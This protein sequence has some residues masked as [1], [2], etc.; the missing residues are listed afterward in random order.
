MYPHAG[1][2]RDSL[3][4]SVSPG[5]LEACS[6]KTSKS[7]Q[8]RCLDEEKGAAKTELEVRELRTSDQCCGSSV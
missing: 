4:P 1:F 2:L 7:L 3:A 5:R 6:G 8:C